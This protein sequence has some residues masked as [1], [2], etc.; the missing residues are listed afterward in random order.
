MD[1]NIRT[2]IDNKYIVV[3]TMHRDINDLVLALVCLWYR[4]QS[5]TQYKTVSMPTRIDSTNIAAS[6]E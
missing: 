1:I 5:V 4:I 3:A 6:Y 2:A